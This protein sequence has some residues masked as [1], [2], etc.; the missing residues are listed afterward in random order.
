MSAEQLELAA[1]IL[2]PLLP[3]VVFVGGATIHLWI[4]DPAA[5]PVRATDDVDVI[6]DVTTRVDYYKL[7]ERLR[8]R[9]L[10][11]TPDEPVIC[12]W[13]HR[14]SR[15]AIDVMPIAEEVLGFTNEWYELAIATAVKRTLTS[16]KVIRAANPPAIV[17]TKLAAWRGRGRGDV[18]ASLDL[19][20]VIALIDGRPELSGELAAARTDLG[21]FVASELDAL[22]TQ[23]LFDYLLQAAVSGY[24]PVARPRGELLRT[25]IDH[26]L[27]RLDA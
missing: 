6:C 16:G 13:R 17:A 14:E 1:D 4:T 7:G 8:E 25:R 11:E 21:A 18:L 9:D 15:L 19:H 24:G 22:R 5:P 26:L 2:G 23:P 27:G 20:D 3:E 10:H 12:R